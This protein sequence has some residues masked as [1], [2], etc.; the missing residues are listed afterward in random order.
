M[1]K[2]ATST[3]RCWQWIAA[4]LLPV[5]ACTPTRYLGAPPPFAR[6]ALPLEPQLDADGDLDEQRPP[7]AGTANGETIDVELGAALRATALTHPLL[8][9]A[10]ER[11][12]AARAQ[13]TTA[14]LWPNPTLGI[15]YS[16]APFPGQRWNAATRQGGPPQFDLGL[17]F[18]VDG[19]LFGKRTA[20]IAGHERNIDTA[21]AQYADEG[22]R[23]L[24]AAID[25]FHDVLRARATAELDRRDHEQ[26]QHWATALAA[27]VQSGTVERP[28]LERAT[29][30]AAVAEQ[31]AIASAATLAD[32]RGAF[33]LFLCGVDG[34]E[35]AEPQPSAQD[36]PPPAVPELESL[37]AQ[38]NERRPDLVAAA[39]AIDETN[40]ALAAEQ[41]AAWPWLRLLPGFS[42]QFQRRAI[43][44]PDADSWSLGLEMSVPLFD[45]NQGNILRARSAVRSA[46]LQQ[47]WLRAAACEEVA[48]AR[49]AHL[50]AR[51]TAAAAATAVQAAAA[52]QDA[53]AA[54]HQS[55]SRSLF[56]L[57]DA[58]SRSRE[59]ERA[60][61]A[62]EVEVRRTWHRLT[63]I[64]GA[65]PAP[66][67]ARSP[68]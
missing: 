5:A 59:A 46:R 13:H 50:A 27:G 9:A 1:Q 29:A 21:L 25:A 24:L 23:L 58:R 11:V 51:A 3:P 49:R 4:A 36:L 30:A 16:L 64:Y 47:R 19:L 2:Q 22:R 43:G 63:A 28:D 67:D 62:A 57:L 15:G 12:E 7:L 17:G 35:R 20:A 37:L 61:A 53:L 38:A 8:R 56:E 44:F 60:A 55:G 39:R 54:A 65:P 66:D 6:E 14:S 34:G 45:R 31:R 33:R 42:R 41:A 10:L 32:A 48:S 68:P 26:L 52:A 18:L 40:A